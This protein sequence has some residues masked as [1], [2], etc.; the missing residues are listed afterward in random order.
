[1]EKG[2]VVANGDE[3]KAEMLA[4]ALIEVHRSG[5]MSEKGLNGR[6]RARGEKK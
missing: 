1:M 6:H 5:N 3:A 2:R 4:K